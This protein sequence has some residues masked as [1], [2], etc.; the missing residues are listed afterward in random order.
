MSCLVYIKYKKI[1][2]YFECKKGH[3]NQC[4]SFTF[5]CKNKMI[6]W[7]YKA[8]CSWSFVHSHLLCKNLNAVSADYLLTFRYLLT[9][10][11][12][13]FFQ[14][15]ASK[16]HWTQGNLLKTM[17]LNK[18][19]SNLEKET[20]RNISLSSQYFSPKAGSNVHITYFLSLK[21]LTWKYFILSS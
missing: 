4:L 19:Q 5:K 3:F 13:T 12:A 2:T 6:T 16:D 15:Q 20:Y 1:T 18:K 9:F 7:H 17:L 10:F 14:K 21:T 8:T 11:F